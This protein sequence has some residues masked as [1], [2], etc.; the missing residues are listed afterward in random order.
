MTPPEIEQGEYSNKIIVTA[1]MTWDHVKQWEDTTVGRRGQE[2]EVWKKH[3][4]ELLDRTDSLVFEVQPDDGASDPNELDI[5]ATTDNL[6]K[7]L[8]FIDKHLEAAGC[9]LKSQMQI[10]VAAEEIFVNIANY[11]YK[12]DKGMAKVRVEVG[13]DP[14]SVSI[15]F[16]DQGVK[17]DP[18]AK[19]DPDVTLSAEERQIGGLGIFLVKNTMD[20]LTYQYLNGSN[21]LTLKKNLE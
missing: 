13:G 6:P 2:Y 8:E 10:D 14:L 4:M 5:E 12:P 3:L 9:P 21:I 16:I 18:L 1:P 20:D 11:A 15:T 7:V 17:Y 19:E